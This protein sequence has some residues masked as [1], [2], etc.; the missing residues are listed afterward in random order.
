MS[1]RIASG[2][3]F[4][5]TYV[6]LL[7]AAA[8][9]TSVQLSDD[10]REEYDIG[11]DELIVPDPETALRMKIDVL[12]ERWQALDRKYLRTGNMNKGQNLNIILAEDEDKVQGCF[13]HLA[14]PL[15]TWFPDLRYPERCGVD[16]PSATHPRIPDECR[17]RC[18]CCG[19]VVTG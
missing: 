11:V 19:R 7:N 10:H 8:A 2:H 6:N 16:D 17:V 12:C 1:L 3:Q 5:E 13:N 14:V 18:G 4:G 9:A 15:G